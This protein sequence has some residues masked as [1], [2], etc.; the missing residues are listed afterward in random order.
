MKGITQMKDQA[1]ALIVEY[2]WAPV[3]GALTYVWARIHGV[4]MRVASCEIQI[5][6]I[7]TSVDEAKISRREIYDKIETV[8]SEL[9]EQHVILRKE[10]RADFKEIR[11]L[12]AS[13]G[14]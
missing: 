8:R 4:D 2:F 6:T 13:I 1:W 3:V 5:D 11:T 9:G 12:I 10:Q 14:K 7:V